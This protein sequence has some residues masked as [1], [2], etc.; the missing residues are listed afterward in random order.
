MRSFIRFLACQ[1]FERNSRWAPRTLVT[2]RDLTPSHGEVP[3]LSQWLHEVARALRTYL[4]KVVDRESNILALL[5]ARVRL[6]LTGPLT[7]SLAAA[8][9]LHAPS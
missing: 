9:A 1:W 2:S 4:L 7:T 5:H 6:G 8:I 3:A